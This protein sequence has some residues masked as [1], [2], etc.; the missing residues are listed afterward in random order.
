MLISEWFDEN[1]EEHLDA[2][3]RLMKS[4]SWPVDFLPDDIEFDVA[5]SAILLSKIAY[6]YFEERTLKNYK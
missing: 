4:G 5:W 6:K 3:G 2:M 1:N